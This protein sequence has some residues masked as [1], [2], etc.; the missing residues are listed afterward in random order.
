MTAVE[1]ERAGP[2]VDRE[3]VAGGEIVIEA[4]EQ[5]L[6]DFCVAIRSRRDIRVSARSVGTKRIG[7]KVWLRHDHNM[8]IFGS[9]ALESTALC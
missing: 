1:E 6:L 4:D 9:T 7:H 5:E 3:L 2:D 8:R